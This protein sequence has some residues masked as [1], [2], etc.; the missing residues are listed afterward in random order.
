M[1][2][3]PVR[4]GA[5]IAVGLTAGVALLVYL[6]IL[7]ALWR[8][9]DCA[10]IGWRY[11]GPWRCMQIDS[12]CPITQENLDEFNAARRTFRSCARELNARRP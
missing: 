9:V 5:S 2:R 10:T 12:G 1:T 8:S 6:L 3:R 11:E 4:L 7:Q